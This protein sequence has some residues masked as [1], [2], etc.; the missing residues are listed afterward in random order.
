MPNSGE[1][2]LMNETELVVRAK[3]GCRQA[4]SSLVRKHQRDVR[5]F[6]ARRI[7]NLET[8]DDLAQDVFLTTIRKIEMTRVFEPGYS[9]LREINPSTI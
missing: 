4:L 6:L 1:T 5:S 3:T 7:G 8:A 9:K 2:L